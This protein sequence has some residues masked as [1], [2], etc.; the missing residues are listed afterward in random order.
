M[1]HQRAM[2]S[3][4]TWATRSVLSIDTDS[5]MPW[6]FRANVDF[7]IVQ[8]AGLLSKESIERIA[9]GQVKKAI[10]HRYPRAAWSTLLGHRGDQEQGAW[11]AKRRRASVKS[12]RHVTFSASGVI[13]VA[14]QRV[15][16]NINN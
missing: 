3:S 4:S 11:N 10:C 14:D 13:Q 16:F 6:M 1:P 7:G 9:E 2:N 5:S 15:D 8:V 12:T